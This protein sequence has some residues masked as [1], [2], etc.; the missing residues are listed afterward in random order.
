MKVQGKKL[1]VTGA[2][3]GIGRELVA[4]IIS[5]GGEVIAVDVNK[6]NLEKTVALAP[7]N[8]RPVV[9]DITN[10]EK[11][12][13]FAQNPEYAAVDGIINNAGIIQPFVKILDLTD[14]DISRIMDV[15]FYGTLNLIRAFLPAL[16]RRPEAH[17]INLSSMGGFLPVPGQGIYGAAK[18]AVKLMTEA[19]HGELRETGVKVSVVFPGAVKTNIKANS[20][21]AEENKEKDAKQ[22]MKIL[23]PEDAALQILDGME[24]NKVRII[25]GKDAK[26]MDFLYRLSPGFASGLIAKKMADKLK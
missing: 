7:E 26:M 9:L 2:G 17:I 21:L 4:E 6:E 10:A 24:G 14:Q 1:I 18:A 22:G 5:R 23:A 8:I 15:N 25:L 20:G 19:L 11:V 13:E 16:L 12:V 3:G